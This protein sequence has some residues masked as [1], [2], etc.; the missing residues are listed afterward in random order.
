METNAVSVPSVVPTGFTDTVWVSVRSASVKDTVPVLVRFGDVAS[1]LTAPSLC[2]VITGVSSVPVTVT[3][4]FCVAVPPWP[5]LTVTANVS[6]NVWPAARKSK[7]LSCALKFHATEPEPFPV[8]SV[9]VSVNVLALV[10]AAI[11]AGLSVPPDQKKVGTA[12]L[13]VCTSLRLMSPKAMLPAALSFVIE[14]VTLAVSPIAPV[15]VVEPPTMV[16]T[17]FVPRMVTFRIS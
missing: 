9:S 16:G 13:T 14:P 7:F 2:A 6:V 8:L 3:T 12:W 1:S 4:T 5:S 17:A 10:I 11:W 15:A